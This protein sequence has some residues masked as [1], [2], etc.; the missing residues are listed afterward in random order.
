MPARTKR[1]HSTVPA[2]FRGLPGR[3]FPVCISSIPQLQL[4][5]LLRDSHRNE[6]L[7]MVNDA[8]KAPT[9]DSQMLDGSFFPCQ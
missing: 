2:S 8:T 6:S 3:L 4:D 1:V 9:V 7:Y 5:R